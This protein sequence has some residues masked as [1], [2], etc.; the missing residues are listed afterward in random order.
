MRKTDPKRIIFLSKSSVSF[1]EV[2]VGHRISPDYTDDLLRKACW[3]LMDWRRQEREDRSTSD[4]RPPS[5]TRK[6]GSQ[7]QCRARVDTGENW[8]ARA[9]EGYREKDF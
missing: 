7:P 2:V 1:L 9:P 6:A 8:A 4:S 5:T 3:P